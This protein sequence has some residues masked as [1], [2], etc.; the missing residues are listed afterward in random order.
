MVRANR[1]GC[2]HT[3]S[4]ALVVMLAYRIVQELLTNVAKHAVA[5]RVTIQLLQRGDVLALAVADNGKGFDVRQSLAPQANQGHYGLRNIRERVEFFG[6]MFRVE[7]VP[8]QG[9]E[10]MIELP[11]RDRPLALSRKEMVS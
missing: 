6:G 2:G 3:R 11:F 10:I 1:T 4:H 8:G 7:S 5:Q 9:S